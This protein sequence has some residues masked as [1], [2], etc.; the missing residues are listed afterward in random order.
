MSEAARN[1]LHAEIGSLRDTLALREEEVR[2]LKES[3]APRLAFPGE[4]RLTGAETKILGALFAARSGVL[5]KE[6]LHVA[7]S[8]LEI[9]TEQKIVD[10]YVHHLRAKFKRAAT[11]IV[12]ETRCGDGYRLP[13]DSRR[14]IERALSGEPAVQQP[15]EPA[16]QTEPPPQQEDIAMRSNL[17]AIYTPP[18]PTAADGLELVAGLIAVAQQVPQ[19]RGVLVRAVRE[20]LGRDGDAAES[21]PAEI[22]DEDAAPSGRRRRKV[23]A[24]ISAKAGRAKQTHKPRPSAPAPAPM[25]EPSTDSTGITIAGV[26]VVTA[27]DN[28]E[29]T[30][31]GKSMEVEARQAQLTLMLA[32][33]MPNPVDRDFLCKR[34]FPTQSKQS[35]GTSLGTLASATKA[36]LAGIGLDV[37][38]VRGIGV[39]LRPLEAA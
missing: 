32:R 36:A 30:F 11:G 13:P 19:H 23:K 37:H 3:F 5:S 4:W 9:E 38:T 22:A 10:V 39:V 8:G 18:P 20:L 29:V 12:I 25:A 2:Q 33:G 14:L 28:E 31:N 34:L 6:S 35:A 24:K 7:V 15:A 17:P 1:P 26:T 27:P 16:P 21:A